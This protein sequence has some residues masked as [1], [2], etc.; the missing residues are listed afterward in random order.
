[1]SFEASF[2]DRMPFLAST[3]FTDQETEY[4][5]RDTITKQTTSQG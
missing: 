4:F 1:M 3:C 2:H 5:Y